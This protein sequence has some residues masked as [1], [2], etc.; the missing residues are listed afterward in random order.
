MIYLQ[1]FLLLSECERDDRLLS[2][3]RLN[4]V[5]KQNGISQKEESVPGIICNID[6]A[7]WE[8]VEIHFLDELE[9]DCMNRLGWNVL[10]EKY[11]L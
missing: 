11:H 4:L 8:K 7:L 6:R 9:C 5:S 10:I 3:S 2:V 1:A